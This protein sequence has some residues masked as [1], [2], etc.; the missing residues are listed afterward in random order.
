M[1]FMHRTD[2]TQPPKSEMK[3]TILGLIFALIKVETG[4]R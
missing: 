4:K 1:S 3:F 2:E